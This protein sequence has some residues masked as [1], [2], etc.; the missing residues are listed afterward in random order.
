MLTQTLRG[1]HNLYRRYQAS[2]EGGLVAIGLAIVVT[3]TLSNLL[4][5]P[6]KWVV[7][8]GLIIAV[9]GI[10]WPMAAFSLSVM[11]I[12]YPLMLINFY[13][14]VLFLAFSV[15]GH[16]LFVHYL[17]ATILV[18][19]MPLLAQYHLHW[20]VPI[21]VGLWW[22]GT[23]GAW[24]GGLASLWGKLIGGLGGLNIDWLVLAGHSPSLA[25]MVSRFDHANSLQ[26]LRLLIEPFSS[27][28]NILLYNLL[29]IMGWA[30]AA[31]FV[32]S[33]AGQKWVKYN[34]PW[35][36]LVVTASGGLILLA[37]HLA[38]PYWLPEAVSDSA[39]LIL[40]NPTGPLFSLLMV[41]IIGTTVHTVRERLDLPVAPPKPLWTVKASSKQPATT[42]PNPLNLFKRPAMATS[43]GTIA[44]EEAF[45]RPHEPKRVPSYLELP[46]WKAPKDESGLIMLEID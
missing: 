18:L 32:G 3:L 35:S 26:T 12:S 27:N 5:Y 16:R 31:G 33:M 40:Q 8:L 4:I 15:L 29:Q 6:D 7:V 1:P 20:L 23:M 37:T 2:L 25:Q 43:A 21:L 28:P 17:G 46:E 30:A 24:V 14:G 38:L 11:V 9:L 36:I 13:L 41:I 34:T 45:E 44:E 39:K 10:R 22:G 19:A 42:T